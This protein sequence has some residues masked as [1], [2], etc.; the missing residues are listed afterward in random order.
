LSNTRRAGSWCCER[1]RGWTVDLL[2][3]L[4]LQSGSRFDPFRVPVAAVLDGTL[5]AGTVSEGCLWPLNR[6]D[7]HGHADAFCLPPDERPP[8]PD[9][10]RIRLEAL[11]MQASRVGRRLEI[12]DLLPAFIEV[13]SS[14][15]GPLLRV[16]LPN[17]R[18][19]LDL[20]HPGGWRTRI[21]PPMSDAVFVGR[22]EILL[23]GTELA[24]VRR[25]G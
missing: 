3:D 22:E 6:T 13:R 23:V 4:P 8:L 19:A 9:S 14:A 2:L 5:L 25:D 16:P 1:A 17:G 7:D 18:E 11:A 12:P 10:I 21:D 24:W 15:A 20:L